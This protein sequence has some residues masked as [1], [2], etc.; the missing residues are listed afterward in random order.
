MFESINETPSDQYI[1][2][3]QKSFKTVATVEDYW[4]FVF[5][6]FC[7]N[8]WQN[9]WYNGAEFAGDKGNSSWIMFANK[10]VGAMAIRYTTPLTTPPQTPSYH[11][12]IPATYIN[13]THIGYCWS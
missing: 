1:L 8:A 6:V 2:G 13:T 11:I 7:Q 4:N 10:V 9:E 3:V 12:N 5:G